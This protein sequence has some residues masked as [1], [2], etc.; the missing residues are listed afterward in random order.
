MQQVLIISSYHGRCSDV[1]PCDI[2]RSAAAWP[3]WP[4]CAKRRCRLMDHDEHCSC[5]LH[6][7]PTRSHV[8]SSEEARGLLHTR[9]DRTHDV[10]G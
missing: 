2:A 10:T 3:L 7:E 6:L 8:A 1:V 9:A 5:Q 4:T